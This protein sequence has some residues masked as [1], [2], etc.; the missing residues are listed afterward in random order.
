MSD[1]QAKRGKKGNF[2]GFK[3]AFLKLL[4]SEFAIWQAQ[5]HSGG[6]YDY[7]VKKFF[8]KFG[9]T[10]TGDFNIEPLTDPE[11]PA[12][13][14]DEDAMDSG[15]QTQADADLYTARFKELRKVR[16]FRAIIRISS[17]SLTVSD[18]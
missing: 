14:D 8:R 10:K 7:V 16:T 2:T 12:D 11:E 18:T 6:F 5:G 15:C 3:L 13:I 9:F 4:T 17:S 1:E